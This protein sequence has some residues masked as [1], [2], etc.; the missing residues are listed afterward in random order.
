MAVA[1]ADDTARLAQGTRVMGIILT[2]SAASVRPV[3]CPRQRG[4]NGFRRADRWGCL[5]LRGHRD[6]GVDALT[7]RPDFHSRTPLPG[8]PKVSGN[9]TYGISGNPF[10]GWRGRGAAQRADL[11]DQHD[12][13]LPRFGR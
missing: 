12:G 4:L 7:S 2:S 5:L 11:D 1:A 13:F 8:A 10:D 3:A 6:E 9:N